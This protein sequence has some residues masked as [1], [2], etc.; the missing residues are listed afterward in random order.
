MHI[1]VVDVEKAISGCTRLR[2]APLDASV[3]IVGEEAASDS[4]LYEELLGSL[5]ERW[6]ATQNAPPGTRVIDLDDP[7]PGP[8]WTITEAATVKNELLARLGRAA[9]H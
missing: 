8:D 2:H 4:E 1:D 7:E 5:V 6:A 3:G 9:L